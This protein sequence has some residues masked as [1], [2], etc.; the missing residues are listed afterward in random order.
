MQRDIDLL[1][2]MLREAFEVTRTEILNL[3]ESP[4]LQLSEQE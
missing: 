2:D 3:T 4:R 1:R